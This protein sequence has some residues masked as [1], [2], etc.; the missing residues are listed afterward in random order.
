MLVQQSLVNAS[1][2]EAIR[3]RVNDNREALNAA[4]I[5]QLPAMI[6]D[7]IIDVDSSLVNN[8]AAYDEAYYLVI[9]MLNIPA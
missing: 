5:D 9:E 1:T 4:G 8:E 6:Y 3:S 7:I 2:L